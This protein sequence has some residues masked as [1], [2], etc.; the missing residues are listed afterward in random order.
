M[1]NTFHTWQEPL[2]FEYG[3]AAQPN[4]CGIPDLAIQ[5]GKGRT[6]LKR[7]TVVSMPSIFFSTVTEKPIRNKD[8]G[9]RLEKW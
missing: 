4:R 2:A 7:D 6:R 8:T 9:K 5:L 3:D 1:F